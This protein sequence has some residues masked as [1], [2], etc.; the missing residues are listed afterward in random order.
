MM[1]KRSIAELR[2]ALDSA[3]ETERRILGFV[4]C[5]VAGENSDISTV[6]NRYRSLLK[7]TIIMF[8]VFHAV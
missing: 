5:G 8:S 6:V 4:S 2:R 3:V 7:Q 1:D